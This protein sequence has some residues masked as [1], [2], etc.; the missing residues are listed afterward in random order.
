MGLR[1]GRAKR[2]GRHT[3]RP[4]MH[5]CIHRLMCPCAQIRAHTHM[6]AYI[7]SHAARELTCQSAVPLGTGRS[8]HGG[9]TGGTWVGRRAEDHIYKKESMACFS[10][11]GGNSGHGLPIRAEER[12]VGNSSGPCTVSFKSE[13]CFK[14][15]QR[16]GGKSFSPIWGCMLAEPSLSVTKR[17]PGFCLFHMN[18]RVRLA[19]NIAAPYASRIPRAQSWASALILLSLFK[20][21]TQFH[22][23]SVVL[24]H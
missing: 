5:V 17:S 4:S 22:E 19:C 15:V 24:L 21:L 1:Q 8:G 11:R 12:T 23:S 16:L 2:L 9:E 6:L 18:M 14:V 7:L 20:G 13:G 10:S 3:C